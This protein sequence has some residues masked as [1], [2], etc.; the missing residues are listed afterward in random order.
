MSYYRVFIYSVFLFCFASCPKPQ[1]EKDG[2]TNLLINLIVMYNDGVFN[3]KEYFCR[4]VTSSLPNGQ[5]VFSNTGSGGKNFPGPNGTNLELTIL[6]NSGCKI[7]FE[8]YYCDW[9]D[10]AIYQLGPPPNP[11]TCEASSFS[12]LEGPSGN[13]IVC[14]INRSNYYKY[15]VYFNGR[16]SSGTMPAVCDFSVKVTDF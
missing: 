3:P 1:S 11:G 2:E 9:F 10:N 14:S 6:D 13:Q 16:D 7:R 12:F 4:N 5:L 8:L 15:A